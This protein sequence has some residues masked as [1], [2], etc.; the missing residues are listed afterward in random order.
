MFGSKNDYFKQPKAV[1]L[2]NRYI[3]DKWIEYNSNVSKYKEV[4]L[5]AYDYFT[6]HTDKYDGATAVRDLYDWKGLEFGAL[7]HDYI[8]LKFNVAS[9]FSYKN[10]ADKLYKQMLFDFGKG[11]TTAWVRKAG[12]D[13]SGYIYFSLF[14][15]L[16][17]GKMKD[18]QKT[19]FIKFLNNIR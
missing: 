18:E 15:R 7:V 17:N 12:L 8:Y 14:N 3:V 5:E 10:R 19:E 13:V 16:K 1:L 11:K 2:S 9:S 4:I 6:E